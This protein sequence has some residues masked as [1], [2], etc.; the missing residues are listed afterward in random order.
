MINYL[1]VKMTRPRLKTVKIYT[2][3]CAFNYCDIRLFAYFKIF[4]NKCALYTATGE[5]V[6]AMNCNFAV[7]C[8]INPQ[9]KHLEKEGF[10]VIIINE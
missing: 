4:K 8:F 7:H 6:T 3:K 5:R 2:K 9:K 1:G 10:K